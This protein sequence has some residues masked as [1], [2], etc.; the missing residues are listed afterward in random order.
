LLLG[1]TPR[2]ETPDDPLRREVGEVNRLIPSCADGRAITYADIGGMLLTP[3][4]V[5]SRAIAPDLLHFNAA[6]YGRLAPKLDPLI[7]RLVRTP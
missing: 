1:L 7:D 3:S 6:G 4:G 5:L 2:G